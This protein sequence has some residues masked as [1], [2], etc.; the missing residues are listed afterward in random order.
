M[1]RFA[2]CTLALALLGAGALLGY[3]P[4]AA[5]QQSAPVWE[6]QVFRMDPVDYQ[7]KAD[8][9]QVLAQHGPRGA[10][11]AFK[12]HVLTYLGKEGWELV[13]IEK[14]AGSLLYL[15]LKRRAR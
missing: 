15:Y 7:D 5:Q 4:A 2:A 9:K 3:R 10:D 13:T 11:A 6:Y 8:Y 14:R 1:N 12:E